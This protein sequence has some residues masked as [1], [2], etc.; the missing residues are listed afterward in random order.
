[1]TTIY[2]IKN[3]STMTKAFDKLTSL[4][5]E[6]NF[7]DYKK[8]TLDKVTLAKW[9]ECAGMDKI[10]NTKGTT[11]RNL[12]E[13]EKTQAKQ[14]ANFAIELMIAKP[15]MIKRPVVVSDKKLLVGF[16]EAEFEQL[17]MK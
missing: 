17:S 1:M 5:I 2:G 8:Q 3:C 7:F 4:G 6:Y 14:D 16:N 15:S 13:E 9:V 11:W 12:T 10:L